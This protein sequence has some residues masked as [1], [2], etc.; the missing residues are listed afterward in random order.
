MFLSFN[1]QK[2]QSMK[3]TLTLL[4]IVLLAFIQKGAAQEVDYSDVAVI[5]NSNSSVSVEIGEY[6]QQARDIPEENIITISVPAREQI[7]DSEFQDLRQQVEQALQTNNLEANINY[8]VTTKGMPLGVA[9]DSF[10]AYAGVGFG[11]HRASV[12]SELALILGPYSSYVGDSM[13]IMNP[14]WRKQEHF[15]RDKFGIFLVTRLDGYTVE[16]V[17]QLID[18]GGPNKPVD[19]ENSVF[20]LDR[21]PFWD[22]NGGAYRELNTRLTTANSLLTSREWNTLYNEDSVFITKQQNV[23]GYASW[24]S[25]DP[26]NS[27]F[28][29]K[30]IPE[31]Q[32][33]PA[34]IAETYVST[35]ARTFSPTNTTYGNQSKVA[36][37]IHE[38]VAGVKGYVYEP[39][40]FALADVSILFDRYTDTTVQQ[41]YNMAEAFSM[42]SNVLGWMD[43]IL[44]DPKTS[45]QLRYQ[46]PKPP[47]AFQDAPET[48]FTVVPN[49]A[50]DVAFVT[51]KNSNESNAFVQVKDLMGRTL[52]EYQ[53]SNGIRLQLETNQLAAGTYLVELRSGRQVLQQ[54]LLVQ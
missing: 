36:E 16:D 7:T 27:Q 34:A 52:Q 44:G 9:R 29:V 41:S 50:R 51:M 20:V 35:S 14:Y 24:G 42:S 32:W 31:N 33:A 21:S 6:F 30:A 12:E 17:K 47:T 38:G 18:N 1:N 23:L 13:A 11:W 43:V 48:I 15:S 39:F 53:V 10:I 4:S 19:R 3:R 54:K 46:Q 49:P 2:M 28:S 45:L 37:L 8:L 26:N 5:V 25:N 22:Q 40:S